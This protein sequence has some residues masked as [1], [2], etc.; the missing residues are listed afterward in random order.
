MQTAKAGPFEV[1]QVWE[2]LEGEQARVVVVVEPDIAGTLFGADV[3]VEPPHL[4]G[5]LVRLVKPAN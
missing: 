3:E 4:L 5:E 1:G 2:T